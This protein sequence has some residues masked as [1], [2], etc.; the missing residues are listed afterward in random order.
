MKKKNPFADLPL[1][2][3]EHFKMFFYAAV[4]HLLHNVIKAYDSQ[5]AAFQ[6]FPF[7][8]GY[9]NEL[10]QSGLAGVKSADA[11]V[12]WL[13][14]LRDWEAKATEH[15]PLRALRETADL[16]HSAMALL[17]CIGLIEED[18]RF[19][20]VF[21]AMQGSP[22]QHRPTLSL[23]SGWWREENGATSGR[24]YLRRLQ[25]AG[26]VRVVN[27]EAPRLEW[28]LEVTGPLWDALRGEQNEAP[29]P[30]FRY[31]AP[32]K[33]P[34]FAELILPE[35]L[36]E[37]LKLIPA[38]LASG[39]AQA[40]IVRGAQR[41]GRRTLL[42]AVARALD[43]G[44]LE[45]TGLARSDDER[46]RAIGPLATALHALPVINFDL[47][48]EET[49]EVPRLTAYAGPT[50]IV[51]GKQGGVT[52]DNVG[53]A[54]SLIIEIPDAKL[55]RLHWL[56]ACGEDKLSDVA[57]ISERFRL[58]GGNIQRAARLA[59]TYSAL[60]GRQKITL[61][62]IQEATRALNRQTLDTLASRLKT[63]GDWNQLAVGTNTRLELE[64]LESRCRHREHL[65]EAVGSAL[66]SRLNP[67]VRALFSGPSG[68]G[69]T[70]A[71]G[72]LAAVLQMDL[73]RLDLSAVVNKY[74]GET[75]KN[76]NQ[77]FSRAEE[78]DVIL[79]LD[80]GDALLTQRTGVQN[81][82]DRYANLETNFLLQRLESFEGI[83]IVT[84]NAGD[85]IDG[86]FRRRMDVVIN[87]PTPD[88]MERWAIWQLHLPPGHVVYD[89]LLE[90]VAHRCE[91]TGGQIRN[92]ILHASLLA[93]EDGGS[94]TS[95]HLETAV[96]R[97]YKKSGAVC[98]LRT[99]NASITLN[100]W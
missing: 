40:L 53:H 44:L 54:L 97:E 52:G 42:G 82:N 1:T 77:V 98:P 18:L 36:H 7:L 76:L 72:L 21:E 78:L 51:M 17:V 100:R 61:A 88:A 15:L 64:N 57:A 55:R 71:A 22:G 35:N 50:G 11:L 89:S 94:V 65:R 41:N 25:D 14:S 30:W 39:E 60:S 68:T 32:A 87:F 80:E 29:A 85:R 62:D 33:L 23:L 48:P 49:T 38:L 92:A 83:L 90:D 10:A 75:E 91:L 12:W 86:A 9:N 56:R 93:L 74:I 37:Q 67:G 3:T 63:S 26:L 45:V 16:D 19:G 47:A 2:P 84:T 81:S 66:G 70:L 8:A 95:A 96:Q 34:T 27:A 4:L 79:L 28:A 99:Y 20:L 31:H 5:E 59:K 13:D 24:S 69:K 46:W 6:Q 43:L 58:T 73:Y